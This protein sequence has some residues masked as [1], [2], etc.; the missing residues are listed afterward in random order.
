P[1]PL[2]SISAMAID[3]QDSRTFYATTGNRRKGA[4][5]LF[6]SRDAGDS[7]SKLV[8]LPDLVTRIWVN[9]HSPA[10][11]RTLVLAGPN[12]VAEKRAASGLQVLPMPPAKSLPDV[13]AGFSA[14]G[15]AVR[16]AIGDES[17]FVSD[18]QGNWRKV[19]LGAG[20]IKARAIATSLQQPDT[21]YLSY[22]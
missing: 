20:T 2:G 12:L 3:P 8:D 5:A 17:A 21:A 14:D 10:K 13:S 15:K 19:V 1:D 11:D 4:F 9:P 7:W 22:R 6:V 16:Y 18:D